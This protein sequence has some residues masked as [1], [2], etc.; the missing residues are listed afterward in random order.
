MSILDLELGSV[1]NWAIRDSQ[2]FTATPK[3]L[4]PDYFSVD[5]TSNIIVVLVDNSKALERWHTAGWIRQQINLPFGPN[6]KSSA[7]SQWLRLR[8]KQLIIFPKLTPTYKIAISFPE[9]FD[10]ASVTVWEYIGSQ[11]EDIEGQ[12]Q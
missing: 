4:L 7:N 1:E 10:R 12:L 3:N 9:W 6:Q 8:E 11:S 5:L 2:S